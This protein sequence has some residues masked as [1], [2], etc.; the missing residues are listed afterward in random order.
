MTSRSK[1]CQEQQPH[2]IV[3]TAETAAVLPTYRPTDRLAKRKR[4][5]DVPAAARINGDGKDCHRG[6]RGGGW[7]SG[8]GGL[9]AG[10]FL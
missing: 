7:Q 5:V 9:V 10:F 2:L 8:R 4:Q 6:K 3:G 1:I